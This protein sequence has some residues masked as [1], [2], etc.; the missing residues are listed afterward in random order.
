MVVC[1]K[2]PSRINA[3]ISSR[4]HSREGSVPL[5]EPSVRRRNRAGRICAVII[6]PYLAA[7]TLVSLLTPGTIVD[8]GDSYCYDIW[9]LGVKQVNTTPSGQDTLYTA[10][11]RIFVDSKH[12]HYLPAK[13]A[14]GFFY[15]LDDQGR[16]YPLLREASFVDADVTIH[17]G[18]SVKSSLAFL[19]PPNARKLYLMGKDGGLPWVY[20]YFGSDISLF[21]RRALLRIL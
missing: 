16:R 14:K 13:Q 5:L 12:P 15:A 20:L 1:P 18:E 9:C 19:A 8:I 17:P 6:V 4:E 11:V 7:L 2:A 10:E 3:R 21:H